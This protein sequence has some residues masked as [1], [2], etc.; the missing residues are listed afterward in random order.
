MNDVQGCLVLLAMTKEID[1]AL[2]EKSVEV[3]K[4]VKLFD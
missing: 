4:S 1:T 3:V 2:C